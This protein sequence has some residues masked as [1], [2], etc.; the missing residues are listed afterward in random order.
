[1]FT[2]IMAELANRQGDPQFGA[3]VARNRPGSLDIIAKAENKVYS[4][5]H[6]TAHAELLTINQLD[7]L[8]QERGELGS[9]VMFSA[10]ESWPRL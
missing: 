10:L 3:V 5:G 4:T 2:E 9:L 7:R 1:M 8:R 6:T